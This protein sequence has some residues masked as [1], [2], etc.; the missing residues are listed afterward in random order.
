MIGGN[1]T[2]IKLSGIKDTK[3]D[4]RNNIFK[5]FLS[6]EAGRAPPGNQSKT[7]FKTPS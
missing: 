7:L 1:K 4:L 3:V 6:V 2:A 5:F